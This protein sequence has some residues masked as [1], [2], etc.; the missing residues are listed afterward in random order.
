MNE[1]QGNV[2]TNGGMDR[3]NRFYGYPVRLQTVHLAN[4]EI[5]T[6]VLEIDSHGNTTSSYISKLTVV[7]N[8]IKEKKYCGLCFDGASRGA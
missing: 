8:G 7:K 3:W 2:Q 6:K 5:K 1:C 4:K